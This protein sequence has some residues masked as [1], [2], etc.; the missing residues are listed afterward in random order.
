MA[1]SV[2]IYL[3]NEVEVLDFAGPYEVFTTASRVYSRGDASLPI[4]FSVFTIAKDKDKIRTRP[5]LM[6]QA[7]YT[8]SNHPAIDLLVVPGGV[9]TAEIATPTVSD[10]I[11]SFSPRVKIIASVCTGFFWLRLVFWMAR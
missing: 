7:D 10:W 3:F 5:G 8:I 1:I 11:S 4:P 6:V 9:V 2:G